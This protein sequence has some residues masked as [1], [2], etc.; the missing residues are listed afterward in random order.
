MHLLRAFSVPGAVL[1]ILY[2]L[3]LSKLCEMNTMIIF[4]LQERNLMLKR[5]ISSNNYKVAENGELGSQIMLI[6]TTLTSLACINC[7]P[8]ALHLLLEFKQMLSEDFGRAILMVVQ[9]LV[10]IAR[11]LPLSSSH[12]NG[13]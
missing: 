8:E 6:T 13:R 7:D 3:S 12:F 9:L 11:T 1:R 5:L 2:S 4:L 10:T